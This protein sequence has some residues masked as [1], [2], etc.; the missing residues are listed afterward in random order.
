MDAFARLWDDRSSSIKV[1]DFPDAAKKKLLEYLPSND[2]FVSPMPGGRRPGDDCHEV[3]RLLADEYQRV[4]WTF[5]NQ[6]GHLANGLRVG[7]V[8]S[9]VSPWTHQIRTYTK[10][11][12]EWP[13][14]LLIA[15]EVG[16]GKT[17]SAG[18]VIRQAQISGKAKRILVMTPKS[19]LIQWQDELYEK[20]NLDVPIYDGASL[21]WRKI[22]G[23]ER[24]PSEG[25][26]RDGWQQQPICL[27]SSYLMRRQDRVHELLDAPDWDLVV[28]DEAHHARRRGAGTEQEKGP[29]A[30][31]GV[32]Q[33]LQAK[34]KSLLLLTATP[35]QVHPVEIWDLLNL[36]GL[37]EEW[38]LDDGI[39]LQYFS[40]AASNP[41]GEK[42]EYLVRMFQSVETTYGAFSDAD[43]ATLL[44]ELSNLRRRKILAALRD[45]SAIPRRV[46]DADSRKGM[47][48]ILQTVT[49]LRYRMIRNTREL[50]R[51]YR[52]EGKLPLPVPDR[53]V[54]D[55]PV[56]MTA[57]ERTLYK[58]VEDYISETYKSATPDK[59]TAVGFIMTV[60][61]RRL[62]S[63]FE[64][65]RCTLTDRYLR[66]TGGVPPTNRNSDEDV[67]QDE[68]KDD[69]MSGEEARELA[70][71]SLQV[72]EK[73]R[74]NALLKGIAQLS[75]TDSKAKEL[76][77]QLRTAFSDGYDSAIVFT[78]YTDTMDYLREH[79]AGRLIDVPTA[80][81]S[82]DGGAWRDRAGNWVTCSKEEIKRKLR[83]KQVRL[84]VCSDAAG[85]GLNLQS[86]GVLVNYDLPWNPMKVE[87]RIGR[88]DRIGQQYPKVR[89][90]NLAYKD[91][92]EYDVFFT[93]GQRIQLFQGIVGKL[94][95][96]LS[97]LPRKFEELTLTSAEA[98]EA[99]RNRFIAEI[100]QQVASED[101]GGL[102]LDATTVGTLDLPELPRPPL[103]LDAIDNLIQRPETRPAQMEWRP[104]DARSY[105]VRLPGMAEACRVT[106][107]AQVFDESGDNHQLFGPGGKLFERLAAVT[108]VPIDSEG[109]TGV[110]WLVDIEN[111]GETVFLVSTLDGMRRVQS[112]GELLAAIDRLASPSP[113]S[114]DNWPGCRVRLVV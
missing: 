43:C 72:E 45:S 74:I 82:G 100:E 50:L 90:I 113:F 92:V 46:M 106:T 112:V 109:G 110:C 26:A 80:S 69:V 71:S 77:A 58:Q 34:T 91:T 38:R 104:L 66:I 68:T 76:E 24:A 83:A 79:L 27:V 16:L 62:A 102:D 73:G 52:R 20:F 39:F 44:P 70:L 111:S 105:A 101:A 15:D 59:R 53:D 3:R 64:A 94:Q 18:L 67:S 41:A 17:I 84:L 37:P 21:Q 49:P 65:L 32:M 93:I 23:L 75:G 57:A 29:N 8:T 28:L 12:G 5:L 99:A 55:V 60:Y 4:V 1:F 95:P 86:C 33:R 56:D 63:S 30:L 9:A 85:E 89:I 2:R 98:R 51:Q 87:Q 36:L 103:D 108:D 25:V 61:R 54:R 6:A 14:R 42:L 107:D 7:E 78:Q 11:L 40:V 47:L 114:F 19:V 97:R 31:L 35:M 10:F 96:I 48:R 81:Y 88:I 22:C 13:S